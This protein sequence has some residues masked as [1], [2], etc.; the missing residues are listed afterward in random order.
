MRVE[1]KT[2]EAGCV[3][4]IPMTGPY[5]QIPRAFGRLYGWVARRGLAP[6][7][8]P[9]GVYLTDPAAGEAAARWELQA[10]LVADA[11]D[12]TL[13][14]DGCGVKHVGPR[15]VAAATYRGPYERIGPA[16]AELAAWVQANGY[17]VVGP[18]EESYLSEPSTPPEETLTEIHFPVARA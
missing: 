15:L 3:A 13:D 1:V 6:G 10:P 16:Y 8:A 7:G 4:Y 14:A 2:T 9:T 5:D 11:P 18:P 12:A 17:A